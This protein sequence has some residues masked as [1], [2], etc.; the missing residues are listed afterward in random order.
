[1]I[2]DPLDLE[3][4]TKKGAYHWMLWRTDKAY[5]WS[6][7]KTLSLI[8]EHEEDKTVKFLD[9]GCGDGLYTYRWSV[10]G[11]KNI[12]GV[13]LNKLAIELAKSMNKVTWHDFK[14]LPSIKFLTGDFKLINDVDVVFMFDV[15]EHLPNPEEVIEHLRKNCKRL[16][17]LNPE[18]T[19]ENHVKLYT[20]E[21]FNKLFGG[22]KVKEIEKY[23]N[24]TLYKIVNV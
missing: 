3:K 11:Y 7:K 1:M 22:W 17:I 18:W 15:F 16:Y 6:V 5:R 19:S 24:K 12:I 8:S 23:Y 20:T 13:D 9:F 4:Y 14:K 10:M 2:H 21:D